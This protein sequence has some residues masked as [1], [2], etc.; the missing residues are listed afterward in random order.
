MGKQQKS[1]D[2]RRCLTDK[3]S[4]KAKTQMGVGAGLPGAACRTLWEEGF[5]LDGTPH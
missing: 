3:G 4:R 5:S 2:A 1:Q